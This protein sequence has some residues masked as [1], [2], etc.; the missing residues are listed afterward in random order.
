MVCGNHISCLL[1]ALCAVMSDM[2]LSN[3]VLFVVLY[4][5]CSYI[6]KSVRFA[7]LWCNSTCCSVVY[8]N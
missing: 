2:V 8:E 7:A 4:I 5:V 1:L 3:T 6:K